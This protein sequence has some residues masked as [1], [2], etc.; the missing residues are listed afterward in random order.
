MKQPFVKELFIQYCITFLGMFIGNFAYI[1]ILD[2][3]WHKGDFTYI[4]ELVITSIFLVQIS[5]W[6]FIMQDV[7]FRAIWKIK[8]R[9][10]ELFWLVLLITIIF[11]I[12]DFSF[13]GDFFLILSYFAL[14]PVIFWLYLIYLKYLKN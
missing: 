11:L 1:S 4:D 13:M 6:I 8:I 14:S 3:M 10:I 12:S 2:F 7:I 9:N 5:L